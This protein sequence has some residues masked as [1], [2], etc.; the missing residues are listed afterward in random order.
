MRSPDHALTYT[1]DPAGNRLSQTRANA[2]ASN[3]PTAVTAANISYDAANELLRWNNATN[4][5]TY[6]LNGNLA[7]ETVGGVT[8]TY[9]W[10]SRNRLTGLS[11]TG[12]TASFVYD[13]LGRRTSKTING[14]TT[15]FWYDG[16]DVY[17]ELSGATPS[18]TYIR[19]LNIDEPYVRKGTSDEFYETDALGSSVALTNGASASQTTCWWRNW[20]GETSM[21]T[22]R[23]S[24]GGPLVTHRDERYRCCTIY[25]TCCRMPISVPYLEDRTALWAAVT[26]VV[27]AGGGNVGMAEHLLHFRQICTVL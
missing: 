9:T 24:Q 7:T 4:N 27:Q 19:G 23:T 22:S 12:L 21:C 8:T 13:G 25:R 5:L 14:T 15:G 11:R 17:A 2:A 16:N 3:L 20:T 18:F 1:Y 6:D 10:D 26:L